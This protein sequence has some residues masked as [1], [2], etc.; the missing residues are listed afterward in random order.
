[1]A[2][3]GS[4]RIA[5]PPASGSMGSGWPWTWTAN[6]GPSSVD[7]T[8]SRLGSSRARRLRRARVRPGKSRPW[9]RYGGILPPQDAASA[10]VAHGPVRQ[11]PALR[12]GGSQAPHP[13]LRC[14]SSALALRGFW[15]SV[16]R[17]PVQPPRAR[18]AARIAHTPGPS[19]WPSLDAGGG[20]YH[21]LPPSTLRPPALAAPGGKAAPCPHPGGQE[22]SMART[23]RD[24]CQPASRGPGPAVTRPV[25]RVGCLQGQPVSGPAF[26]QLRTAI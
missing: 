14:P 11:R 21:S 24:P 13:G 15:G 4:G 10:L 1:M 23:G 6:S 19:G 5:R 8:P 22:P 26:Q 17:F 16:A 18:G 25:W 9:R 2:G 7:A 3:Q 20:A 12:P